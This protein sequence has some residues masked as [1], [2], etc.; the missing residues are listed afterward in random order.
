MN[1][2]SILILIIIA[3]IS[4]I[5]LVKMYKNGGASCGGSCSSCNMNCEKR[6]YALKIKD[7]E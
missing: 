6:D 7:K 2:Q 3:V 1:I 4:V 5:V